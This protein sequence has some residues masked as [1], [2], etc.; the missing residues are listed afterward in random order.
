MQKYPAM[1][2]PRLLSCIEVMESLSQELTAI[3]S[4]CLKWH[5]RLNSKKAKSRAVSRS[6]AYVPDYGD[7]SLFDAEREELKSMR[8]LGVTID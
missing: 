2:I 8:I 5:M 1:V 7:L 3:D 4:W 6:W